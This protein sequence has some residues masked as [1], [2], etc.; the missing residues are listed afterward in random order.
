[1]NK[2]FMIGRLTKDPEIRFTQ[3]QK[4]VASFTIAVD[5]RMKREGGPDADFFDC[6]AWG[7]TAEH[8]EKYWRKGMKAAISGRIET[9]SWTTR[10][11]Q[12][13]ISTKII[14][15]EIEFCEKKEQTAPQQ[16]TAEEKAEWAEVGNMDDEQL[17]FNF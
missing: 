6:T 15:D 8:M 17:P 5:R 14:I 16:P 13:R 2:C 3:E 9:E 4:A 1:M 12:K 11:G 7:K 10:D